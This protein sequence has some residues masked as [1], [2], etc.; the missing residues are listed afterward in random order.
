MQKIRRSVKAIWN[1]NHDRKIHNAERFHAMQN[2]NATY[3]LRSKKS[4]ITL[5]LQHKKLASIGKKS[6][7]LFFFLVK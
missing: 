1:A 6:I 5:L 3:D 7:P 4:T 2:D